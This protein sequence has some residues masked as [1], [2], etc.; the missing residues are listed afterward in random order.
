MLNILNK[1]HLSSVVVLCFGLSLAACLGPKQHL[2]VG[3]TASGEVVEAEGLSAV[4]PDLIGTKKAALEDARK[5]AV[6]KVVGVLISAQ[7][8]VDKAIT[9]QQN[10]LAKTDGYVRNYEIIRE[11]VESDGIYHTHIRAFVAFQEI[12]RDLA[13]QNLLAAPAVENPRVAILIEERV[14]KM[15]NSLGD[16]ANSLTQELIDQGYTV[17]DRNAFS[18]AVSKEK[19]TDLF[20]SLVEPALSGIG[21]KLDAEILIIGKA[22]TQLLSSEGLG[23]LVSFRGTLT[24]KALK[25]QSQEILTALSLQASALDANAAVSSQKSLAL[26]GKNA[27]EQLGKKIASE[28]FRKSNIMLTVRGV[29]HVDRLSALTETLKKVSGVQA[30]YVRSFAVDV[31]EIQIKTKDISVSNLVSE[32]RQALP[33]ANILKQTYETLE[34][35]L[36]T[37]S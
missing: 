12:K 26:L 18:D 29:S 22:D 3:T 15:E 30:L 4:T 37:K 31:A 34:I 25:V 6:E 10:I 23:G 32:L 21:K 16:C 36:E 35:Q 8:M 9:V 5:N 7:T 27:A 17:V 13:A 19:C 33:G 24:V 14:E 1:N 28:L 11:G 2:S 20:S